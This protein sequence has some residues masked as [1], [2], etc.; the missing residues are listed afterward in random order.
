MKSVKKDGLDLCSNYRTLSL[1][2]HACKVLLLI[3]LERLK[4][5]VKLYLP[6]EQAGFRSDRSTVQHALALRLIAETAL[7]KQDMPVYSHFI[8]FQKAFDSVFQDMILTV[9]RAY[10]LGTKLM[11]ILKTIYASAKPTIHNGSEISK[12]F[13]PKKVTCQGNAVSPVIF[14]AFLERVL[15]W[16]QDMMQ[17]IQLSRQTVNNL[18]FANNICQIEM[19]WKC[20]KKCRYGE[21]DAES[22]GL[23]I[24]VGKMKTLVIS[25][26]P[27]VGQVKVDNTDVEDVKHSIYLGSLVMKNNDCS[28]KIK[29]RVSMV[30]GTLRGL[31]IFGTVV[32]LAEH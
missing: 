15:E 26:S 32:Q 12:R 10:G 27:P 20:S 3:L 16:M 21:K 1:I 14:M 30:L 19:S 6:E 29:Q 2:S 23:K 4:G 7:L 9:L 8:S 31:Q 11:R 5:Y 22:T 18:Q 25:N 24:N 13:K 17:G 28:R